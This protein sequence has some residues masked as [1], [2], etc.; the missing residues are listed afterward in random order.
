MKYESGAAFRQALEQRLLARAR[1]TGTSLVRLRKA[2]TFD[3]LLARFAVAAPD[4][5]VLKGALALDYW[6]G[7]RTRTTKDIDLMRTG[8]EKV[9]AE[10][11]VAAL[12]VDL[13]DFFTFSIVGRN[14]LGDDTGGAIEFR[15]R[16]ELAG[17]MFEDVLIDIGFSD[18]LGWQP[19]R[20]R[21]S[22]L[23]AFADIKPIEVSVLPLEQH[24][25]EKI[26]AY[27]RTYRGQPSSRVK[28]LVDI[29]LVKQVMTL[30]A[31]RLRAALVGTFDARGTHALPA[32]LQSPPPVWA[33]A[34]R[35]LADE[36]GI[37]PH[38]AGGYSEA[39]AFLDPILSGRTTGH[40][41]PVRSTWLEVG[42]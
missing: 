1:E 22:N 37:D 40:W 19:D 11:L 41:D 14:R 8:D 23:L 16:S 21:G 42:P 39:A 34:Y 24:V 4:S 7:E 5:W 33:V 15:V 28:D 35:K 9:A 13:G 36:I 17:R 6:I 30:G 12:Q 18:P 31:A 20:V 2:V 25:A 38:L 10:D 3:R 27:T 29:V 32:K 26:H